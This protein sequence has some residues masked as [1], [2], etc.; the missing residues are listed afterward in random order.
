MGRILSIAQGREGPNKALLGVNLAFALAA[1][2][3]GNIAVIDLSFT[4]NDT[5]E[6]ISGFRIERSVGDMAR[7]MASMTW[8]GE[9]IL[10][11][12]IPLSSSQVAFVKGLSPE[13]KL[14]FSSLQLCKL[15]QSVSAIYP[16]TLVIAPDDHTL[17]PEPF[18]AVSDAILLTFIPHLLSL[19]EAKSTIHSL[20][21]WHFPLSLVKPVAY[22][23][24]QK[25]PLS[26][27]IVDEYLRVPVFS[28]IPM[29]TEL[30]SASINN[31]APA[32][33]SEPHSGFSASTRE[34]AKKLLN[35]DTFQV[36]RN[37]SKGEPFVSA[38]EDDCHA[39]D[40]S[41][42][43]DE[44]KSK[45]HS[46]L[47]TELQARNVDVSHLTDES[48]LQK[49]K[50]TA[51]TVLQELMAK[52]TAAL[53]R[54]DRSRI[55]DELLD[56]VFG[57]GCLEQ[58]LKDQAITEIMVNG[59]DT[60]YLEKKGKLT[61]AYGKRFPS[62]K[63]LMTA[64]E[65]IVSPLGRRVNESSP[66]VDAR[67]LD[68]SRVNIIIPPLAL[69]GPT[70]TIRKFSQK[71]LAAEDLIQFGALNKPMADFL[72]ICVQLRK[73]IVVSGG[74]GSGKTTLL[75]IVSSFIPSDERICTIE[76]SA[77]L[78]LP[79]EHVVRLESRPPS[80]EG[81]GE[82]SIRRLVINALRMRPDRIVVG[83]CRG[84]ET[85]DMLQAMNTGHDGSLTTIHANTPKDGV[86][87]ITTMVMMAGMDLS[88]KA[89]REQVASAVNIMVQLTR[90]SD[91]S[92]KVVEVAE[93]CGIKNDAVDIV[94]LFKYKQTGIKEGKVQGAFVA[95][96]A[97]PSFL[98]E[99]ET[100]GLMLDKS[101][102]TPGE[103]Q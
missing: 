45:L 48:Q 18:F 36:A 86:A 103:L 9:G 33:L 51:R 22:T 61:L 40:T 96:G 98:H 24:A 31:G 82:I 28:E 17:S 76:D 60:I 13:D 101:I 44:L 71:K 23:F 14:S 55:I 78:K 66:L 94:P 89:I 43:F 73:N 42:A 49:T 77:E 62:T 70:I 72:K 80:I 50:E 102:F 69:N 47:I 32:I 63:Q 41:K 84:G 81:T 83:E 57:L 67:L 5:L 79:Q 91:G 7:V 27:E 54:E 65:R 53:Q 95:T 6:L 29:D 92:R 100:H 38:P 1:Q 19:R 11:G 3:K 8:D 88:E 85:L 87:R 39:A 56:D 99:A 21:S 64:I 68:G 2:A 58:L 34:L 46:R 10:K 37:A 90:L 25:H 74:T 4:G 30:I 75:N 16:Y 12:Y 59:P 52:E 15:L 97:L 35:A 26:A 20:Q 93:L